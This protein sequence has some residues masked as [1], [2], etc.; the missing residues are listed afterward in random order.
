METDN[1]EVSV[2]LSDI[3]ALESGL[4]R[5]FDEEADS[6]LTLPPSDSPIAK[7]ANMVEQLRSQHL[8]MIG[9]NETQ[10]VGEGEFE[11]K[12]RNQMRDIS[13][14]FNQTVGQVADDLI[15]RGHEGTRATEHA[16]GSVDEMTKSSEEIRN[17]ISTVTDIAKDSSNTVQDAAEKAAS[18]IEIAGQV[19]HAASDIVK[20]TVMIEAIALQTKMLSL[21]A[22]IEAARAGS[23]GAGFAVVAAEVKDLSNRTTAAAGEVKN[24]AT[25]MQQAAKHMSKAIEDVKTAN[26]GVR[27]TT[28]NMITAID[29]QI[30]MTNEIAER[31]SN[32]N[33]QMEIA[34]KGIK[35]IQVEAKR[36]RDSAGEFVEFITAE[37]G[38]TDDAVYFGQSAPYSGAVSSLGEGTRKG[39]ELS[40]KLAEHDGGIHGRLPKLVG[41]D[42]GYDP[43]RALS[44]VRSLVRGGEIFALVG[45]V[46]TPTSKL[47]ERIARGGRVPFIGPVTGTGFLRNSGFEHVI[48]VRA[49]YG[50]EAQ[51][52]VSTLSGTADLSNCAMFLQ[53]DAYGF[54]VRT[55]IQAALEPRGFKLRT[56]AGYDRASGDVSQAIDIIS[57]ASPA[58]VFMAGTAGTSAKFLKGVKERRLE[59]KFATISFVGAAEFARQ[60]GSAGHGVLVSQVV[61]PPQDPTSELAKNYLQALKQFGKQGEQPDFATLEG[62]VMGKAICEVLSRCGREFDRESFL[63]TLVHKKTTLQIHDFPLVYGPGNNT[64]TNAV[65]V[66]RLEHGGQY[67]IERAISAKAA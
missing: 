12:R 26:E 64:G 2:T 57:D 16:A 8:R 63:Q 23:H 28:A 55:A 30:E 24:T 51:A 67:S 18:A 50:D 42:D 1:A 56:I 61:P 39:I 33:I 44:N 15:E 36:L 3:E 40:F 20:V 60:A 31:A 41:M 59:A 47:S 37:P 27:D 34:D 45:A 17:A 32:T 4:K 29:R 7:L 38:V 9:N 11:I 54:A 6:P 49:S 46:G 25:G 19:N 62:F 22:K 10:T 5:L 52:L 21:N 43:D 13:S 14:K 53:S 48:N 58:V 65:F 35:A 66:T